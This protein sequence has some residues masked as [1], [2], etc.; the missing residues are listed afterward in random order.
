ML[1]GIVTGAHAWAKT[2]S[3]LNKRGEP[4]TRWKLSP[5]YWKSPPLLP[6]HYFLLPP[7]GPFFCWEPPIWKGL[8]AEWHQPGLV[9]EKGR[10]NPHEVNCGVGIIVLIGKPKFLQGQHDPRLSEGGEAGSGVGD[11]VGGVVAAGIDATRPVET[12]G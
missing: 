7:T 3:L 9:P 5:A 8:M 2:E 4:P 1:V 12:P 10:S 11:V 6:F